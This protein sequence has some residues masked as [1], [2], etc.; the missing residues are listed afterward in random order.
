L[1]SFAL[2]AAARVQS[3]SAVTAEVTKQMMRQWREQI[4][5][6]GS[7]DK[8]SAE[9]DMIHAF[10]D[11]TAKVNGRVA[12]GT[13]HRDVEEVIVLMREMQKLAT[14]ATLDAPIL[15]YVTLLVLLYIV[16]CIHF[17]MQH[18]QPSDFVSFV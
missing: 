11:L 16:F 12:F 18:Q 1:I 2:L 14:A 7:G 15:W 8:E 17:W 9:I 5:I 13:S 3:M 4:I 10:N 6:Q